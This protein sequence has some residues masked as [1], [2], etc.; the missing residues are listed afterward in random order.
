MVGL[1]DIAY[2]FRP[3]NE[4]G[5]QFVAENKMKVCEKQKID[6]SKS[7]FHFEWP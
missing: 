4:D 5:D 6:L 2:T 3:A 1:E 7:D